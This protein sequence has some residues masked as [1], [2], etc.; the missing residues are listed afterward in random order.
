MHCEIVKYKDLRQLKEND[1]LIS[2]NKS[3][4]TCYLPSQKLVE[5]LAK[6]HQLSVKEHQLE[7]SNYANQ[8]LTKLLSKDLQ[9]QLNEL[10]PPCVIFS[11]SFRPL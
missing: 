8:D 2:K 4:A 6:E 10:G 9:N 3:T 1:L 7:V 5:S 11:H